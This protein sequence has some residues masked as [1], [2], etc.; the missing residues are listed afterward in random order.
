MIDR[1][2]SNVDAFVDK[3][4]PIGETFCT[5]FL[6]SS[7]FTSATLKSLVKHGKSN[8]KYELAMSLAKSLE[9][10]EISK[11]EV[12]L[13]YALQPRK[14]LSFKMGSCVHYPTHKGAE[15]LLTEFGEDGWYGP[16]KGV[17]D[18]RLWYIRTYT[19]PFYAQGISQA[20]KVLPDDME[21]PT[22]VATYKIRWTVLAEIGANYMSL[23]WNGFRHTELKT[24]STEPIVEQFPYW[25]HIPVFFD[26]LSQDFKT[27][28]QNPVLHK[29]VLQDL[30]DKYL[31]NSQYIWRHLRVR[32]DNRGVALNVHSTGAADNEE[33][34]MRGL[35]ALS[36]ELASSALRSLDIEKT[37]ELVGSVENALLRTLIREWGTRSYEFSLNRMSKSS[38]GGGEIF[39][40]HC[41]FAV[42]KSSSPQ[43]SFQHL[44]CFTQD[45]GGSGQALRF[46]LSELGY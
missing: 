8:S 27:Q 22:S 19:V 13:A 24:G 33:R 45:Y 9:S 25:K 41:Y 46:L 15:V 40:A 10:Q 32:A 35:Q 39:R 31:G 5:Q 1:V 30:W 29:L 21:K 38:D 44:H 7:E 18:P 14:W 3:G 11:D 16:I 26:E 12:L 4:F 2:P 20:E 23:S 43:D 17:D 42:G 37:S 36:K 28:W 6:Y 34:Q